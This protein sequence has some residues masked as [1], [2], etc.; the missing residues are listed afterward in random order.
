VTSSEEMDAG[1]ETLIPE[2]TALVKR[3]EGELE[4]PVAIEADSLTGVEEIRRPYAPN[5]HMTG[6]TVTQ[7]ITGPD[8]SYDFIA[9]DTSEG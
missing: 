7:E 2:P 3:A 4:V 6:Q 8:Y 5:D 1:F 9:I